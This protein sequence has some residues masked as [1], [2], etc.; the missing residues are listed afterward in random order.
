VYQQRQLF[1]G[2]EATVFQAIRQ[3]FAKNAAAWP[4]RGATRRE[5]AQLKPG[6][7]ALEILDLCLLWMRL[8]RVPSGLLRFVA[9]VWWCLPL[10]A[11]ISK[12]ISPAT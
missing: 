7:L 4:L 3:Q 2:F 11:L 9:M 6:D 8:S 12:G 1:E 5:P 10:A